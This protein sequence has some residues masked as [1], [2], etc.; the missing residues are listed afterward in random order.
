VER[1]R[2]AIIDQRE[3]S[4]TVSD[5]GAALYRILVEPAKGFLPKD[6][7]N[8][9][10]FIVPDG[11]LNSLNFET[12]LVPETKEEP[13]Q[14]Y[15]IEDVTISSASS[16]RMLQAFHAAHGKGAGNLLLF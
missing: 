8:G 2:K 4:Q 10:V 6:A 16:L 13:K 11:S 3:S 14:H 12:L 5:D 1:Y 7:K 9:K 15:W